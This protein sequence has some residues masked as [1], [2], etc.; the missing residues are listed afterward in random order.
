MRKVLFLT[1]SRGWSGGARQLLHLA[2]GLKRLGWD[3]ALACPPGGDIFD[4]AKADGFAPVPFEPRQDYDVFCARRL[5]KTID[6][7]GVDIVHAHHPRAH[8]VGLIAMYLASRKPAFV[9][10]RRVSFPIKRNPF[11]KL[12]Y[13]S[14]RIT[15]FIAV[16]ESIRQIL[17]DSG[18]P[19]R[20]VVTIPSGVDLEQF[21]P[22]PKDEALAKLLRLEPGV[23]VIGLVANFGPWKGQ[24][25]F[26][27]A[28]GLL[29]R[30]G[31]RAVYLFAGRDT[32]GPAL[33]E[34]A[35]KEGLGEADVRFLGF[36]ADVPKLL[37]LLDVSVNASTEGEGLSGALRESLAMEIPVIAS[38]IGGNRE[39][40]QEGK[41][42]RLFLVGDADTLS[43]ILEETISNPAAA[44]ALAR[45]GRAEVEKRFS[46]DHMISATAELYETLVA[47]NVGS[48]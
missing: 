20:R 42:G 4:R 48:A 16:A 8:A 23:P 25:V 6:E 5:A 31:R 19:S 2:G 41:T 11:S 29:K 1:E 15:R 7:R 44:K 47:R 18:V 13:T 43:R 21:R 35:A 36:F 45:A 22:A 14:S 12:K 30:R 3:I 34:M 27:R 38:D 39:L 32:D 33:K 28:A 17:I 46:V 26:C 40:V 37:S 24:D 9:V 10:T